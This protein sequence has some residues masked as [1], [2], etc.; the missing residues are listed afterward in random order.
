[1]GS[2]AVFQ[3]Q[4]EQWVNNN[5]RTMVEGH[6]QFQCKACQGIQVIVKK[7]FQV[8]SVDRTWKQKI[9]EAQ[10]DNHKLLWVQKPFS[11]KA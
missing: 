8:E 2:L 5:Q 3:A 4:R 9:I 1:V 10:A 7:T 6:S 11:G